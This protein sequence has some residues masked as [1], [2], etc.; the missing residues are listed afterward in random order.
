LRRENLSP[1][2]FNAPSI[3]GSFSEDP[4]KSLEN[5]NVPPKVSLL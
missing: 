5:L 1:P 3:A 4:R 2:A